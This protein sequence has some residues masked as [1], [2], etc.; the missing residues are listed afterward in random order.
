MSRIIDEKTE[1]ELRSILKNLASPV[2]LIFFTQKNECPT[3]AR[4]MQL[5]EE[6][7]SLS[8]KL[9][10]VAYDF[11]LQGDRAM[12]YSVDKIPAT[13]VE[14]DNGSGIRFYGVTAG[15]EFTSLLESIMMVSIGRSGLDSRMESLVSGIKEKVH[16]QVIVTLT[17]P[18]C[19]RMVR[20]ADQFTFIN[21]NIRADMI[22][23][24]E[25]PHLVQKYR[26]TGV[27]TAI[28]NETHVLEGAVPPAALYLEILKIVSPEA[29]SRLAEAIR[30]AQGRR[31]V[32]AVEEAN[33]YEV[34]IVGAG[35]AGL[36]AALYAVRKGLDVALVGGRLGGQITYTGSVDNYL[37]FPETGGTDLVERFRDHVES[38]PIA[39]DFRST[40]TRL[41]RNDRAFEAEMHDG[42]RLKARSVVYCA[43]KEYAR[44]G[45]PGEEEL[46]GKGIGFC[47]TC[48]APLYREKRVA[49]IGGGNSAFTAA[50]DLADFASEVHLVHRRKGFRAD[51][52]LVDEVI[53]SGRVKVHTPF[54]VRS[55]EGKE[56]LNGVHI[57]SVDG[58]EEYDLEVEGVF[59]EIGL[60]PNTKP[61]E[62]L[63]PLKE[64]GEIEVGK[65]QSTTV[66]GLFAAGDV[67]DVTEKQISIAVGQGA[68]AA[69]SVHRYLVSNKLTKSKVGL[70]ESWQ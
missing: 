50:R 7:S 58:S 65:D 54:V 60:I 44:L 26:V 17:C 2:K 41:G 37:G 22:E 29:Y 59:I 61:L 3:C 70:K 40:V 56:R 6:L 52:A 14:G 25:F 32:R 48:D 4:Q 20:I 9:D 18:V 46:I 5:L 38:Y 31:R 42:R 35:P 19:P 45:V 68:L 8:D 49:V 30:E 62:G 28:I 33:E 63:L 21:P 12:R 55:F 67:T 69:I 47:A 13:I 23:G 39:A 10:L 15:Y 16:I 43:G 64:T 51:R 53:G 34:L 66:P 24:S 11:V 57:A 36:S 1:A 27:P